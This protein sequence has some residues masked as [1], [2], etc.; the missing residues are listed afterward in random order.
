MEM[1]VILLHD[2]TEYVDGKKRI[3][4]AIYAYDGSF[5][6]EDDEKFDAYIASNDC[7]ERVYGYTDEGALQ[8]AEAVCEENG[9]NIV[10]S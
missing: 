3:G 5:A 8:N 10:V 7:I 6:I 9:Y 4:V 2:D 1:D